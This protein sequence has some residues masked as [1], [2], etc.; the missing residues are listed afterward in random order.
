MSG[1]VVAAT[2]DGV[3]RVRLARPEKRNALTPAMLSAIADAVATAD[4][5]ASAVIV[6]S[7]EPGFVRGQ[8]QCLKPKAQM[9]SSSKQDDVS[10]R[11]R[12][13]AGQQLLAI[14][15]GRTGHGATCLE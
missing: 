8:R 10:A 14:Q 13:F 12:K 6:L 1:A 3:T 2:S 7:G 5:E 11:R 15:R 4:R 9:P